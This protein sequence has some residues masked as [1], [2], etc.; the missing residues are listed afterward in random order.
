MPLEWLLAQEYIAANFNKDDIKII[1]HYIYGICSDGDLME[2]VSHE[3]A[4][5]QGI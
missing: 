4:S 3:A 5:L 1:D 2:G